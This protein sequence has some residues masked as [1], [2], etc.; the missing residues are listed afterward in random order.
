VQ[1]GSG[2]HNKRGGHI[3]RFVDSALGRL[4]WSMAERSGRRRIFGI[5][6]NPNDK[7]SEALTS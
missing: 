7:E 4:S 1:R 3:G 5:T 2:L 6:G